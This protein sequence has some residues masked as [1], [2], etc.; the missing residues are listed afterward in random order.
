[1]FC[2]NCGKE[3][4]DKAVVCTGCG[5]AVEGTK[6]PKT[7]K[8]YNSSSAINYKVLDIVNLCVVSAVAL[9]TLARIIVQI[10]NGYGS[11]FFAENLGTHYI[12]GY[13]VGIQSVAIFTSAIFIISSFFVF[14]SIKNNGIKTINKA[15]FIVLCSSILIFYT[16]CWIFLY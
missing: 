6:P 2:Y 12:S 10:A 8:T 11:S 14:L 5:V 13:I 1:M 15:H 16:L 9:A 7:A 4:D 3:I